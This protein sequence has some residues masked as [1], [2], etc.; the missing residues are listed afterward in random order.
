MTVKTTGTAVVREV[1]EFEVN[2][3]EVLK[4]IKK[5]VCNVPADAYVKDGKV[6][7]TEDVSRHG[8]PQYEDTE[9]PNVTANQKAIIECIKE[10]S[11][12]IHHEQNKDLY[13]EKPNKI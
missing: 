3:I 13:A 10:L 5:T 2:P 12:R 11:W 7:T 1:L 4:D 6:V 8:S 9:Y